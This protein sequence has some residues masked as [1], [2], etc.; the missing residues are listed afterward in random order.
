[1]MGGGAEGWR[2]GDIDE[3]TDVD[4]HAVVTSCTC[5]QQPLTWWVFEVWWVELGV[6][7]A[8]LATYLCGIGA[9]YW[10]LHVPA[11]GNLRPSGRG[12]KRGTR[13]FRAGFPVHIYESYSKCT[14]GIGVMLW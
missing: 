2:R 4:V 14:C 12:S 8:G 10:R 6:G 5:T 7:R 11:P 9:V 1:M 3:E 13:E